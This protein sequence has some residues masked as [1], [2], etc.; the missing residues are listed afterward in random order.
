MIIIKILFLLLL[1]ISIIKIL[2]VFIYINLSGYN[3]L[4][5]SKRIKFI[6]LITSIVDLFLSFIIFISFNFNR[7]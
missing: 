5:F 2:I 6:E 1:D 3:W 7:N 4:D